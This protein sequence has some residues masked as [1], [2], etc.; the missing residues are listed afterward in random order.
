MARRSKENAIDW[1]AIEKQYRLG[2]KS[3]TQLATEFGVQPSSIGRRAEKYGWVVD[4]AE[5][6]EAVRNSLLIQAASGNARPNA[7]PSALEVQAAGIAQAG[8]VTRHQADLR[9]EA[10]IADMMLDHIESAISVMTKGD[11]I[12][13]FVRDASSDD[14]AASKVSEMLRKAFGRSS[15]VDDFKKVSETKS[16][17]RKDER[18]AHGIDRDSNKPTSPYEALLLEVGKKFGSQ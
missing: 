6:V 8:V 4:K 16:R 9:R 7:S 3:N 12:V 14:E 10:S 17:I 2:T 11:D 15:I 18:E 1:D 13:K 5:E